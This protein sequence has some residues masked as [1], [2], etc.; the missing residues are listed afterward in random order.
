MSN[1]ISAIYD[2]I[3]LYEALCKKYREKVQYDFAGPNCY[4]DHARKLKD[5]HYKEQEKRFQRNRKKK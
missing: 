4:G 2:D 3:E 5:R 1:S